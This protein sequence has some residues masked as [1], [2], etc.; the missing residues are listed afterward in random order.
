MTED[1]PRFLKALVQVFGQSK[2]DAFPEPLME[3]MRQLFNRGRSLGVV[4][5]KRRVE[6]E[7]E[8]ERDAIWKDGYDLGWNDAMRESRPEVERQIEEA[9]SQGYKDAVSDRIKK[10]QHE[11]Q[12]TID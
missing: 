4:D 7:G 12:A 10:E 3:T 11:Q 6:V 1:D 8:A 9:R 5:E 2:V